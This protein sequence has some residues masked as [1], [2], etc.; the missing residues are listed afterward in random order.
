M[1]RSI[2]SQ[3]GR[4]DWGLGSFDVYRSRLIQ[5]KYAE[6]E[7]LGEAIN[8]PA[9]ETSVYIA[10][11][12]SLLLFSSLG[13][14]DAQ[15]GGGALYPRSDLYISYFREGKWTVAKN[16]GQVINSVAE[17]SNPFVSPDGTYLFFSS[18]RN[19][20]SVPM[21]RWI[22]HKE[23]TARLHSPGN[24]LSDIYQVEMSVLPY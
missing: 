14:D 17:E 7:N 20:T 24:G 12:E 13:R 15:A 1:A 18:E 3:T 5:G 23:L 2:L 19:F 4:V 21:N 8:S 6:P 22:N 10:P 11:N 16:L 9:H